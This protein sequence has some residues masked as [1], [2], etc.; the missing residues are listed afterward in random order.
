MLNSPPHLLHPVPC[1]SNSRGFT[2]PLV[3]CLPHPLTCP[4]PNPNPNPNLNPSLTLKP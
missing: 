1:P 4:N 3:A 2:A